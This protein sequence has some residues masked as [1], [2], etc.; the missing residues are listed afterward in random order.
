[1]RHGHPWV[2]PIRLEQSAGVNHLRKGG[3]DMP[4]E[5]LLLSFDRDASYHELARFVNYGGRW[6]EDIKAKADELRQKHGETRVP[7]DHR[8]DG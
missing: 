4:G 8:T 7:D 2:R 6:P 5:T 1:M 3:I